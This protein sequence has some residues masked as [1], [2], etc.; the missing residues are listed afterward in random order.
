MLKSE[1][2]GNFEDLVVAMLTPP[3]LFDAREINR[4]ISVNLSPFAIM[5]ITTVYI[6]DLRK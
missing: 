6:N 3:R 4:A 1:L 2:G 5:P